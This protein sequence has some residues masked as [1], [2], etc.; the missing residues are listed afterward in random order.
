MRSPSTFA[1]CKTAPELT[2]AFSGLKVDDEALSCPAHHGQLVLP[3]ALPFAFFLDEATECC[4]KLGRLARDTGLA[5]SLVSARGG[6]A[7]WKC[8]HSSLA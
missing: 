2:G 5:T 8:V 6:S 3:E 7:L 4:S 1:T